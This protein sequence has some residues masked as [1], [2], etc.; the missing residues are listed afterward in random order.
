MNIFN[1]PT[2]NFLFIS[3]VLILLSGCL[4]TTSKQHRVKVA[5]NPSIL[6]VG[7]TCNTP[8]LIYKKNNTFTGL[9][10]DLAHRFATYIGKKVY[11]IHLDL[12][13]QVAALANNEIDIIMS[14]IPITDA[15]KTQ[16]SFSN[17]Y[18]RSGQILLVRLKDK[19]KLSAGIYKLLSS[20]SIFGTVQNTA[21]YFF[22]TQANNGATIKRFTKADD[23]VQALISNTIDAFIYDAPMVCH[24]AEINKKNRLAPILTLTTEEYLA[25][26]IRKGDNALRQKANTFL[27]ELENKQQ[28]QRIIRTWIPYI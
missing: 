23:A 16:I 27:I 25:W 2:R 9:E 13:Q 4:H 5:P 17:P 6:R 8:P 18:L 14:G 21:G 15:K 11:F 19:E 28:L 7:V 22:I 1:R 12:K 26:G 3:M 10:A 20:N 24:Y